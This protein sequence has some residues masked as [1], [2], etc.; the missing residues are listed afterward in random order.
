MTAFQAAVSAGFDGLETDLRTTTDGH[1]YLGHDPSLLRVAGHDIFIGRSHSRD[2]SALKLKD[3]QSLL[4]F[5]RFIESF[6]TLPWT[7]DIKPEE[8]LATV[9]ALERLCEKAAL[10]KK[11]REQARFLFWKASHQRTFSRLFPDMALVAR[12]RECYRAGFSVLAGLPSLG[13]IR[14]GLT[15][16]LPPMFAGVAL[17]RKKLVSEYQH[18]GARVV[19]YL[20]RTPEEFA[21]AIDAGVDEILSDGYIKRT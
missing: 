4:T 3:G 8:A 11:I 14:P 16:A 7:F 2:L 20:P 6:P 9:A 1:I 15:Y 12:E 18:R 13:S 21:A 5:E 10:R 19:A 17:Y